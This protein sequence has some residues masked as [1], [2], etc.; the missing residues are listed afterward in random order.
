MSDSTRFVDLSEIPARTP[1]DGGGYEWKPVRHHLDIRSFG[2]NA[3]V[4][5]NAGDRVIEEHDELQGC[6]NRHEE[7]Y[8]VLRGRA[9]FTCD[10]EDREV[11]PGELV[12]VSDPRVRRGAIGLEAGTTVIVVGGRPGEAYEVG[13]W[14]K[15]CLA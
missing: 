7:L 3:F 8:L 6:A 10:G 9:R 5:P 1:C 15:R 2:V 14:E 12:F 11:G 4:A 13:E